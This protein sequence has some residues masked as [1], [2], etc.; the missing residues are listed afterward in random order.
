M[1]RKNHV[2]LSGKLASVEPISEPAC[3]QPTPNL[4]F[5]GSVLRTYGC[6]HVA[7]GFFTH[8]VHLNS[9]L[10]AKITKNYNILSEKAI[11]INFDGLLKSDLDPRGGRGTVTKLGVE[12]GTSYI[13]SVKRENEKLSSFVKTAS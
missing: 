12:C 4:K 5:S 6:H 9:L 8:G 11:A 13:V 7:S 3:K 10:G 1:S 2:R